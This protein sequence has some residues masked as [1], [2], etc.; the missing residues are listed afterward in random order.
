MPFAATFSEKVIYQKNHYCKDTICSI[1]Y[2]NKL[3]HLSFIKHIHLSIYQFIN[4]SYEF[5]NSFISLFVS[6]TVRRRF[7]RIEIYL[8][9]KCLVIIYFLTFTNKR[10]IK[11]LYIYSFRSLIKG[12]PILGHLKSKEKTTVS[13]L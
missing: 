2:Q 10:H 12:S 3:A 1:N 11:L 5:I 7:V 13:V 4:S 8:K 6:L 9:F